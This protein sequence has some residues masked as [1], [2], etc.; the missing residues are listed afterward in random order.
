MRT[1]SNS[2][3]IATEAMMWSSVSMVGRL[4]VRSR[5]HGATPSA[6]W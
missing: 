6:D 4:S 1:A 3:G 2:S 5:C